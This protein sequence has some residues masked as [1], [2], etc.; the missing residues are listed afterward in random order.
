MSVV[1]LQIDELLKSRLTEL[2]DE[3]E[4]HRVFKKVSI[5]KNKIILD[6][7]VEEV[8]KEDVKKEQSFFRKFF[9]SEY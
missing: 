7:I 4:S 5:K 6:T 8:K 3:F 9:F 1:D 2:M